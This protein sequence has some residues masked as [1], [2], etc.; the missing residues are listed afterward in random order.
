[1][2]DKKKPI[3]GLYDMDFGYGSVTEPLLD[4]RRVK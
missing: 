1:M 3:E 2:F 4:V